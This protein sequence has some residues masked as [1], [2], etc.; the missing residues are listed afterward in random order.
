M[1]LCTGHHHSEE[2]PINNPFRRR[3]KGAWSPIENTIDYQVAIIQAAT[4]LDEAGL[5]AVHSGSVDDMLKIAAGWMELGM[6]ML[7]AEQEE[8]EESEEDG[9]EHDL[10]SETSIMGFG[11]P[12]AREEA[13]QKY[14]E[15]NGR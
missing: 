7:G 12:S 5:A 9:D 6:N 15:R 10:S 1:F 11:S 4:M 14:E 3:P 2:I 13:E 8:A